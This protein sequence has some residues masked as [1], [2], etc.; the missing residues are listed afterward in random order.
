VAEGESAGVFLRTGVFGGTFSAYAARQRAASSTPYSA[1]EQRYPYRGLV[2]SP[3][4]VA[5]SHLATPRHVLR[6]D[7][8]DDPARAHTLS[9]ASR[10]TRPYHSSSVTA[11]ARYN[12]ELVREIVPSRQ[13]RLDEVVIADE[14]SDL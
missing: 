4:V 3:L 9:N 12:H 1:P 6:Q 14:G 11:S 7:Q 10:P 8:V 2:P 13:E 5:T